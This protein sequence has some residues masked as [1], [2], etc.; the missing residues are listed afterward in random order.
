M[1]L[2]VQLL[3]NIMIQFVVLM[4]VMHPCYSYSLNLSI[5]HVNAV[6]IVSVPSQHVRPPQL[7]H[8]QLGETYGFV[9]QLYTSIHMLHVSG[10]HLL[11]SLLY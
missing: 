11:S 2:V 9:C 1:H 3:S 8:D 7:S 6:A 4:Y 10:D 5:L